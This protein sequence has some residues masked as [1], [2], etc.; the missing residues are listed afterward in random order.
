MDRIFIATL[1]ISPAVVTETLWALSRRPTPWVPDRVELITTLK[2]G[3]DLCDRLLQP[4]GPLTS[5]YGSA[6]AVPPVT[7]LVPVGD[8]AAS[9]VQHVRLDWRAETGTPADPRPLD[10]G[11]DD[12]NDHDSAACMGD[13]ILDRVH[14]ACRTGANQLHLSISG[15]RKTMSAHALFSLGLVGNPQDEAS[16][17]LIAEPFDGNPGFWHPDQGGLVDVRAPLRAPLGAPP[18]A[19]KPPP[20][21]AADGAR[22]LRLFPIA[23]PRYDAVPR[24]AATLPRLS[25]IIDQ[26]NLAGEWLRAPR[27]T[28]DCA[29]N[30]VTLCGTT[31][32]IDTVDFVWL[33]LLATAA[34]EGWTAPEDGPL[35]PPGAV[36]VARLLQGAP[37]YPRLKALRGWFALAETAAL[38]GDAVTRN[39]AKREGA[40][41]MQAKLRGWLADLAA[42]HRQNAARPDVLRRDLLAVADDLVTALQSHISKLGDEIAKEFG[43]PV[44]QAMLPRRDKRPRPRNG[45]SQAAYALAVAA[46]GFLTVTGD[47]G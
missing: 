5:L 41:G 28:L 24:T 10:G 36:T 13:L 39:A 2:G 9:Q 42:S 32:R 1:G 35:Q 31:R 7:V 40:A 6:A 16:H 46:P 4:D 45:L 43:L 17:V 23:A 27:L 34:D 19:P 38:R 44:A 37:Q 18:G 15:G 20:V 3:K 11:L 25:A 14:A 22:T 8:M 26:M 29:T 30:S 47:A 12:V 33:R 21:P